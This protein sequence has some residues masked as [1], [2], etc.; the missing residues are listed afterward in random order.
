MSQYEA[1]K[2][3]L[4]E[5]SECILYTGNETMNTVKRNILNGID[6]TKDDSTLVIQFLQ[7]FIPK[8][9]YDDFIK[10]QNEW[11]TIKEPKKL[12]GGQF[13]IK[14]GQ[15]ARGY[16][17]AFPLRTKEGINTQ[18]TSK[19][20]TPLYI[21]L[22]K[23]LANKNNN[24]SKYQNIAKFSTNDSMSS[25][26][27]KYIVFLNG[28]IYAFSS[29]DLMVNRED[30]S[31]KNLQNFVNNLKLV[32]IQDL[33]VSKPNTASRLTL[34]DKDL[35][36]IEAQIRVLEEKKQPEEQNEQSEIQQQEQEQQQIQQ[37]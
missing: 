24:I 2:N 18:S 6:K 16:V 26:P 27:N 31:V 7:T 11:R 4:T 37:I 34:N 32:D 12:N 28:T 23:F 36:Q 29:D 33:L 17:E 25:N 15:M 19:E 13:L 35:S 8:L 22:N 20:K 14:I 5:L 30:K 1:P 9:S 21:Y 3:F 10:L